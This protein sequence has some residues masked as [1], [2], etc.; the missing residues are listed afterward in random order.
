MS[1]ILE[2][3]QTLEKIIEQIPGAKVEWPKSQ[4]KDGQTLIQV[5]D[6]N[7]SVFVIEVRTQ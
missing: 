5:T 7:N 1:V 6:Q 3:A 2:T 4:N